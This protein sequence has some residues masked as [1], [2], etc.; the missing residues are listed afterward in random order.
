M[1]DVWDDELHQ[2][3]WKL[4][5][6]LAGQLSR[7]QS[8]S[9][10]YQSFSQFASNVDVRFVGSAIVMTP[11]TTQQLTSQAVSKS[12]AKGVVPEVAKGSPKIHSSL[13][14][15]WRI[16]AGVKDGENLSRPGSFK[17]QLSSF[18]RLQT[19][20]N[21]SPN[22]VEATRHWPTVT[23]PFTCRPM[24]APY[25][26]HRTENKNHPDL[27]QRLVETYLAQSKHPSMQIDTIV[28]PDVFQSI[29]SNSD[30]V[31][32][33]AICHTLCQE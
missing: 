2:S 16:S 17:K 10:V 22:I 25:D 20:R 11:R 24:D 18:H 6:E 14:A 26:L 29:D 32:F 1:G 33:Q 15:S 8:L 12:A 23:Y 21:I 7:D 9:E 28:L 27:S 13:S 3:H 30:D 19:K 31:D 4:L 5:R